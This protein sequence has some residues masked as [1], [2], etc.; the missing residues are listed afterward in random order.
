MMKDV[1]VVSDNIISP[2]GTTAET[3]FRALLNGKSGVKEHSM[4]LISPTAFY[5]SLFTP[6][7]YD[8]LNISLASHASFTKFEKL[9]ALSINDALQNSGVDI[10]SAETIL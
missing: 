10:R 4:P 1:Y 2:V 9:L 5:A 3:N 8:A 7:I 6:D